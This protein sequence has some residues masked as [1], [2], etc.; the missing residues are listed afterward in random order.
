[1]KLAMYSSSGSVMVAGSEDASCATSGKGGGGRGTAYA[2]PG[3]KGRLCTRGHANEA[4]NGVIN[5]C[6]DVSECKGLYQTWSRNSWV[7]SLECR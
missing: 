7:R 6:K 3:Q 4:E 2:K 5:F 1:V